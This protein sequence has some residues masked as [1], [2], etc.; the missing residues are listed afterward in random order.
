MPTNGDLT[1][2]LQEPSKAK[3]N[4]DIFCPTADVE[5]KD[6]KFATKFQNLT[7]NEVTL[8]VKKVLM[9]IVTRLYEGANT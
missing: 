1:K 8:P 4:N 6:W 5:I 9:P 3:R 2:F 7:S